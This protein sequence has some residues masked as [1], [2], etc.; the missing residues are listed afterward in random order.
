MRKVNSYAGLALI[1][2]AIFGIWIMPGNTVQKAY[3]PEAKR[4]VC[5]L[6]SAVQYYWADVKAG[7][8]DAGEEFGCNILIQPVEY[9]DQ[10]EQLRYLEETDFYHTDGIIT[11]GQPHNEAINQKIK[12]IT[13]KGVPVVLLD[14]D[15]PESGRDCY[16]G[17]DNFQAGA[18]AARQVLGFANEEKIK[19]LICTTGLDSANQSERIRGFES[20]LEKNE[21]VEIADTLIR[22]SD[23]LEF[24]SALLEILEEQGEI[25]TIFCAEASTSQAVGILAE[26]GN[27]SEKI[28]VIC[29]D[30]LIPV[31]ELVAQG[32]IEGMLIQ[33]AYDM[34]YEAVRYLA[35]KKD[36][37]SRMEKNRD[38][39]TEVA[40]ITGEDALN[41]VEDQGSS[42]EETQEERSW[43]AEK[44]Q[45]LK[46]G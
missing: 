46:R 21:N 35:E 11:V 17:S 10:Q 29:F 26:S 19:I 22:D 41:Y 37:E 6:N 40:Y 14:T 25:N 34:G 30:N 5:I 13:E 36:H 39:Y 27:L 8:A 43:K 4:L 1:A 23:R 20:M 18:M 38:I 12:E 2:L 44:G 15:S 7:I 3:D 33:K 9:F 31:P 16:I 45:Q 32:K 24:Q 42:L 28:H